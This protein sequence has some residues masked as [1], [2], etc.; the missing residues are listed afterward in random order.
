MGKAEH[1]WVTGPLAPYATSFREELS[2]QGYA[3]GTASDHLRLMGH[4]SRWIVSHELDGADLTATVVQ[5]FVEARADQ[6][7]ARLGLGA[8]ALILDHLRGLGVAPMPAPVFP[9]G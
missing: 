5:E 9:D 2:N 6:G 4:L 8:L 3:P 7:Y 1:V